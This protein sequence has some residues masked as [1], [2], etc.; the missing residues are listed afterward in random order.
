MA[1]Y[2]SNREFFLSEEY[3]DIKIT[4][5]GEQ[6]HAHR[7]IIC[8]QSPFFRKACNIGFEETKSG[9]IDLPEDDPY[10]LE[11]FLCFLYTGNYED[12]GYPTSEGPSAAALLS[13]ERIEE[14]LS[15]EPPVLSGEEV[16]DE[17]DGSFIDKED[18]DADSDASSN[19]GSDFDPLDGAAEQSTQATSSQTP[20]TTTETHPNTGNRYLPELPKDHQS[21]SFAALV[22]GSKDWIARSFTSLLTALRVYVMADKFDVHAARL[23]ARERFYRA[24]LDMLGQAEL[25]HQ[26]GSRGF[27]GSPELRED[28][29][30]L[31][32]GAVDELYVNTAPNDMSMREFPC[33]LIADRW[34]N[35]DLREA[36]EPVMRKHGDLAVGVLHIISHELPPTDASLCLD[37]TQGKTE[38]ATWLRE[39]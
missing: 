32:A 37:A 18:E 13:L 30:H 25:F 35:E 23:L 6:F 16:A 39:N 31:F 36:V 38:D 4:C 21:P 20:A 12:E 15:Q 7:A 28:L 34:W 27:D 24:G 9:I 5:Q 11:K 17:N 14:Y 2:E 33:R 3:S 26:L 19:F 22:E 1:I 8:S 10:I 29:Y